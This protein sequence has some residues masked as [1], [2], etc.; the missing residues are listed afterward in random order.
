MQTV[1]AASRRCQGDH[2]PHSAAPGDVLMLGPIT[3]ASGMF[4]NR[5][6]QGAAILLMDRFQPAEVLQT[7]GASA[8]R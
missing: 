3:H 1:A 7:I 2:G 8:R 6:Y 5:L 4:V